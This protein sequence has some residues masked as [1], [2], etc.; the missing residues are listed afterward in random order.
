[1][2]LRRE[3]G[4][5]PSSHRAASEFFLQTWVWFLEK[6]GADARAE[7]ANA[8]AFLRWKELDLLGTHCPA[9]R[10]HAA[11]RMARKGELSRGE[12]SPS[13]LLCRE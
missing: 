12:Q 11:V 10:G 8:W 5:R 4:L 2:R 1:M 13:M 7:W 3:T 9:A 6:S